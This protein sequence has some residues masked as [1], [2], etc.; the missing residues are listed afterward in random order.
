MFK[1]H[2]VKMIECSKYSGDM[3]DSITSAAPCDVANDSRV[4]PEAKTSEFSIAKILGLAQRSHLRDD[5]KR[6]QLRDDQATERSDDDL[7]KWRTCRAE[8]ICGKWSAANRREDGNGHCLSPLANC[9]QNNLKDNFEI[10][11]ENND[12]TSQSEGD[13]KRSK[14][15]ISPEFHGR[16]VEDGG[17]QKNMAGFGLCDNYIRKYAWYR[18]RPGPCDEIKLFD[19]SLSDLPVHEQ[20]ANL[21]S[22][23]INMRKTPDMNSLDGRKFALAFYNFY[24]SLGAP[25]RLYPELSLGRPVTG[26]APIYFPEPAPSRTPSSQQLINPKLTPKSTD[27]PLELNSDCIPPSDVIGE[28]EKKFSFSYSLRCSHH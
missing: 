13:I 11:T 6:S 18:S 10:K 23:L 19:D 14:S 12:T 7:E 16:Y 21:V 15:P 20:R 4:C 3:N 28:C 9:L 27:H 17:R 26:Q 22:D 2:P 8:K 5:Q 1:N 24:G 25:W